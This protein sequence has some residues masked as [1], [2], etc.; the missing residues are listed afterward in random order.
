MAAGTPA[1]T[2]VLHATTSA[3]ARHP[4]HITL[5]AFACFAGAGVIG[6]LLYAALILDAVART[7]THSGI[8]Q[9]A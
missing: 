3:F 8:T 7:G 6:S 9:A 4:L 5:W 2:Q 1:F